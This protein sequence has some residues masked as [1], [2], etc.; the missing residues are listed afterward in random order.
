MLVRS[1]PD[2]LQAEQT[3]RPDL[4]LADGFAD[5]D[6]SFSRPFLKLA[7]IRQEPPG[8]RSQG[9][10][11]L[12]ADIAGDDVHV[13]GPIPSFAAIGAIVVEPDGKRIL[14]NVAPDPLAEE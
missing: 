6:E 12:E 2:G 14:A 4:L 3:A 11:A 5:A 10:M 9:R 7:A 8:A 1:G 13:I